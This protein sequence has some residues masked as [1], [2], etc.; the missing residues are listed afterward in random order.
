MTPTDLATAAR[1]VR[2]AGVRARRLLGA[3]LDTGHRLPERL[4]DGHTRRHPVSG[5]RDDLR[6]N[7]MQGEARSQMIMTKHTVLALTASFALALGCAQ[8][9]TVEGEAQ[10]LGNWEK[11]IAS[12]SEEVQDLQEQLEIPGLA[13]AV[14][15]DGRVLASHAF[16]S[17]LGEEEGF[18]TS[19][20]L[21]VNS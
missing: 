11:N 14:I 2:F 13:F 9:R 5:A 17:Q 1:D 10:E 16:G 21:A 20:P 18:T 19:T 15:E 12:F 7:S 4:A 3:H 6:L 8:E